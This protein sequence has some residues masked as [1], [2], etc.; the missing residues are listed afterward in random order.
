MTV[1]PKSQTKFRVFF[2]LE[3]FQFWTA[4]SSDMQSVRAKEYEKNSFPYVCSAK[5][6]TH[7][8]LYHQSHLEVFIAGARPSFQHESLEHRACRQ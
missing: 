6:N 7:W 8:Q 3:Q 2:G 1:S 4:V 5:T